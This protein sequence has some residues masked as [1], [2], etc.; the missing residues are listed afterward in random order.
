MKAYTADQIR[1]AERPLLDDGVPL[2]HRAAAALAREITGLLADRGRPLDAARVLLLIGP[3]DNGG[4]ALYA[5]RDLADQG[6]AVSVLPVADRAHAAGLEAARAAGADVLVD[7]GAD[8]D[9]V[10]SAT[11]RAA[12]SADVIV[13][14][15][16]GTGARHG[17]AAALRG[18]PRAAVA[19]VLEALAATRP[20]SRPVVVAVDVPS[21]ID[22]DSG[23]VP[24]Q[25]VL[26]ATLTVTFGAAKAGLLCSPAR[27]LA[28]E[29][30]VIDIGLGPQLA[31]VPPALVVDD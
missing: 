15:I 9:A 23:A 25:T 21:G 11:G 2:M 10:V 12:R 6:V 5:G 3:G 24:D 18:M 16:L 31:D 14:G 7:P 28:G 20:D 19:A 30:S 17:D 1:T 13:D 22:V 4:D 8:R 29:L 27:E 26:P